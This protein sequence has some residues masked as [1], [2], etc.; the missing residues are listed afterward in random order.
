MQTKFDGP[1]LGSNLHPQKCR[2]YTTTELPSRKLKKVACALMS[3]DL[4]TLSNSQNTISE[5]K[6]RTNV[7][8]IITTQH[9]IKF[10]KVKNSQ[11]L[12]LRGTNL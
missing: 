6:R 12:E 11:T 8:M 3:Q 10:N 1:Y 9:L 7:L 5:V 2:A 4:L